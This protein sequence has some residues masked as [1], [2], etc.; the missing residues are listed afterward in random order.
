LPEQAELTRLNTYLLSFVPKFQHNT[1]HS[2]RERRYVP[3]VAAAH[4]L[5]L[6][7]L[8][9][10]TFRPS[11]QLASSFLFAHFYSNPSFQAVNLENGVGEDRQAA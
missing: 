9:G 6:D 10:L 5:G 1:N 8:P 2:L 4:Q 3:L 7:L 11:H